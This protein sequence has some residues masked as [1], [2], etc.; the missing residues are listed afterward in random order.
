[1]YSRYEQIKDERNLFDWAKHQIDGIITNASYNLAGAYTYNTKN[2]DNPIADFFTEKL[3]KYFLFHGS[4]TFF[5]HHYSHLTQKRFNVVDAETGD[6][7]RREYSFPIPIRNI[8]NIKPILYQLFGEQLARPFNFSVQNIG[9]DAVRLRDEMY[10]NQYFQILNKKLKQELMQIGLPFE[11]EQALAEQLKTVP[12]NMEEFSKMPFKDKYTAAMQSLLDYYH[13]NYNIKETTDFGFLDFLIFGEEIYR[14]DLKNRHKPIQKI[15]PLNCIY[16]NEYNALG[17]HDPSWFICWDFLSL[18][19]CV[20]RFN[21]TDKQIWALKD[22]ISQHHSYN[23]ASLLDSTLWNLYNPSYLNG[24]FLVYYVTWKAISG[25]SYAKG[26]KGDL[27]IKDL[28]DYHKKRFEETLKNKGEEETVYIQE[29]WEGV[30]I[31]NDIY[32]SIEPYPLQPRSKEN[33]KSVIL[34]VTVVKTDGNSLCAD[35]KETDILLKIMWHKVEFLL[36]QAKG[37]ILAIDLSYIPRE[38]NYDIDKVIYHLISDGVL[39]YNS[40]EDGNINNGGNMIHQ[41]DLGVSQTLQAVLG[42]IQMLEKKL[43]DIAGVNEQ[44]MAQMQGKDSLGVTKMAMSQSVLRTEYLN[45]YH[46][47]ALKHLYT[48]LANFAKEYHK[49]KF[50]ALYTKLGEAKTEVIKVLPEDLMA[51]Y[52]LFINDVTRE[53]QVFDS[54]RAMAHMFIQQQM[55]D[56]KGYIAIMESENLQIAK[57]KLEAEMEKKKQ[58]MQ[59]QQQQEGQQ[60]QQMLKMKFDHEKELVTLNANIQKE[61]SQIAEEADMTKEIEKIKLQQEELKIEAERLATERERLNAELHNEMEKLRIDSEL[62]QKEIDSKIMLEQLKQNT[63]LQK[64]ELQ[65]RI[66]KINRQLEAEHQKTMESMKAMHNKEIE[67]MKQSANL[68]N[69]T[70]EANPNQSVDF[71]NTYQEFLKKETDM[72][73]SYINSLNIKSDRIEK[74][75]MDLKKETIDLRMANDKINTE[76]PVVEETTIEEEIKNG[77]VEL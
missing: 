17:I 27:F 68:K 41:I 58:E 31:G 51:S 76:K 32:T 11:N 34:P 5:R 15:S 38:Y 44:R 69:K 35:L 46:S 12:D 13:Y 45:R 20:A 52:S 47:I 61:A 49:E 3:E 21:L 72:L 16:D 23:T 42:Y 75:L 55:I 59:Q 28:N 65:A 60:E 36:S 73:K 24:K 56:V 62:K 70:T 33:F 53:T 8:N 39:M 57:A 7:S 2:E 14:T 66:D 63:E 10:S 48:N 71:I 19:E 4:D 67:N 64:I 9:K 1:M 6:T 54:I 30:K 37:A 43:S 26:E 74:E 18:D 40:R 25:I 50:E 77:N 29:V 22:A